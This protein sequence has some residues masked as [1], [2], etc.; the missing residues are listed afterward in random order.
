MVSL[1]TLKPISIFKFW[2]LR[3]VR[4]ALERNGERAESA[5]HGRSTLSSCPV[6]SP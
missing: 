1:Y 6:Y 2:D 5:A 3:T 4:R